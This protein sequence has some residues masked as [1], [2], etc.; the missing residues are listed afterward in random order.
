[1]DNQMQKEPLKVILPTDLYKKVL[2]FLGALPFNQV[3][4]LYSNLTT[5]TEAFVEPEMSN[6]ENPREDA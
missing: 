6:D 5:K 4:D 3:A 1:M 2:V